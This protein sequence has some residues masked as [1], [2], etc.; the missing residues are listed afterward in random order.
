M[1]LSDYAGLDHALAAD[2]F[3]I[4]RRRCLI[5]SEKNNCALDYER[6]QKTTA[7]LLLNGNHDRVT[8]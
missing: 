1:T 5:Q 6:E 8:F 4:S 7:G 3:L 2:L